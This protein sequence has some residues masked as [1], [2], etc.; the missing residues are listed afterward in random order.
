[1]GREDVPARTMKLVGRYFRK[2]SWKSS[3]L[4][5]SRISARFSVSC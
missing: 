1:M 3:E 2:I 4:M 5:I